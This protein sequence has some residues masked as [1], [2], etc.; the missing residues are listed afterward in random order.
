[1]I[2]GAVGDELVAELL[3]GDFEGLCVL[4]DLLLVGLE[5]VG[6][7]LFEGYG[8]SGDGVV[9]WATLVTWE[10]GEVDG[11][12]EVVEDLLAGLCVSLPHALSE[13][14]HGTAGGHGGTCEWW[15]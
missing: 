6:L 9:V 2:V 5:V 14:D 15:W 1:M 4:D 8:E 7:G 12:F 10:D 11:A 13:E 3:E